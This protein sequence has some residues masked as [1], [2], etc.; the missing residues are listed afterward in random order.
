MAVYSEYE[1]D[2]I[3]RNPEFKKLL[4]DMFDVTTGHDHDGTNTKAVSAGAVA[5]DSITNV[6]INSAAAIDASKIEHELG[7]RPQETFESG[8]RKTVQWYLDNQE[9]WQRVLSGDYK[10]ERIGN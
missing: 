5:D 8:M 9:W 6:K 10:L 7:W 2:N 4:N 1:I 3:V